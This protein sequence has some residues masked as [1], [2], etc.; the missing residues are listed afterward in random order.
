MPA[1]KVSSASS[2]KVC[3]QTKQSVKKLTN[4]TSISK[5][6]VC[7]K[8]KQSK[9]SDKKKS[10][11][12]NTKRAG[13]NFVQISTKRRKLENNSIENARLLKVSQSETA[14]NA[15]VKR[16]Q[17][18]LA[19]LVNEEIELEDQILKLEVQMTEVE[20]MK[21]ELKVLK[22]EVAVYKVQSSSREKELNEE[23]ERLQKQKTTV[24]E[25][26]EKV[27]QL[28]DNHVIN[29]K[30]VEEYNQ[31][32]NNDA[33]L[34]VCNEEVQ[35][36][37]NDAEALGENN[38]VMQAEVEELK[39]NVNK[40]TLM[41]TRKKEHLSEIDQVQSKQNRK[42][43]N[44]VDAAVTN[45]SV[46]KEESEGEGVK[47]KDLLQEMEELKAQL[48]VRTIAKAE[49]HEKL[50][51]RFEEMTSTANELQSEISEK[52]ETINNLLKNVNDLEISN[53]KL[54]GEILSQKSLYET[55]TETMEE[56]VKGGSFEEVG[57]SSNQSDQVKSRSEICNDEPNS[58]VTVEPKGSDSAV[59]DVVS[60]ETLIVEESVKIVS[61]PEKSSEKQGLGRIETKHN[62]TREEREAIKNVREFAKEDAKTSHKLESFARSSTMAV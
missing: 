39:K 26:K 15:E 62:F 53:K 1:K 40:K 59:G 2:S 13:E 24:E 46:N 58:T 10:E 38:I 50:G 57:S 21:A 5:L 43:Q 23:N 49:A 41:L 34:E 9:K 28:K 52:E 19:A 18:S 3:K 12:D 37:K 11:K 4:K 29:E 54:N 27:V 7:K 25:L 47:V 30:Q 60:Q 45:L 16:I 61:E 8:T 31:S 35:K 22:V 14:S 56:I 6:K 44:E 32:E 17:T 20:Q 42:L 48:E 55:K 33:F 36:F 51:K